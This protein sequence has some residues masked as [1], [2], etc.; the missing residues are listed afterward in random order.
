[1]YSYIKIKNFIQNK[2]N[3][4]FVSI[5]CFLFILCLLLFLNFKSI[6]APAN[7]NA[8]LPTQYNYENKSKDG[9]YAS[10]ILSFVQNNKTSLETNHE[11]KKVLGRPD[12]SSKDER[13]KRECPFFRLNDGDSITLG[14]DFKN[15]KVNDHFTI[16]VHDV[17][18]YINSFTINISTDD[19]DYIP[20]IPGTKTQ[21]NFVRITKTLHTNNDK[22]NNLDI[23]AVE[24]LWSQ[25]RRSRFVAWGQR[26]G[27]NLPKVPPG[28]SIEAIKLANQLSYDGIEIDIRPTKDQQLVLLHDATVEK[29][30]NG[31][32]SVSDLSLEQISKL[33][34]GQWKGKEVPIPTLKQALLE[35]GKTDMFV[36]AD[37]RFSAKNAKIIKLMLEEIDFDTEKFMVS[38]YS[39]DQLKVWREQAPELKVFLKSYNPEKDIKD[40]TLDQLIQLGAAGVMVQVRTD[41]WKIESL[42]NRTHDRGMKVITFIHLYTDDIHIMQKLADQNVDFILTEHYEQ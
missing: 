21:P 22:I 25:E 40:E 37:A 26:V 36:I 16:K 14:F 19:I 2:S 6:L 34:K 18:S 11:I 28:N 27:W 20:Y 8:S 41:P 12:Y 9:V 24:V 35:I 4:V 1:M 39:I 23:D 29:E 33:S 7:Q 31:T 5:A 3:L 30:T 10:S 42:V 32:G 13:C 38:A 15:A 17:G